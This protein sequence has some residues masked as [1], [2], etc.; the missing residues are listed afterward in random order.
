MAN[1][2]WRHRVSFMTQ[3]KPTWAAAAAAAKT[4]FS[5]APTTAVASFVTLAASMAAL[6]ALAH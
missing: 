5:A 3:H 2:T 4:Q 6:F 1:A